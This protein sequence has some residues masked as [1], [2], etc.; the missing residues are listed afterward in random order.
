VIS[1]KEAPENV[2]VRRDAQRRERILEDRLAER[3]ALTEQRAQ[4][5][6]EVRLNKLRDQQLQICS[7]D[8]EQEVRLRQQAEAAPAEAPE[9]VKVRR[10]AQR[11][12]RI[13]EDR[14]AERIALT[15]QRARDRREARLN[16]LRDQQL[17]TGSADLEEE[18][19]LRQ[20]AE[21]RKARLQP[22]QSPM[23]ER[24][25]AQAWREDNTRAAG[26]RTQRRK[27][28]NQARLRKE[29]Q[30]VLDREAQ[31]AQ[32]REQLD[33]EAQRKRQ[34]TERLLEIEEIAATGRRERRRLAQAQGAEERRRQQRE[35]SASAD[36]QES[37]P[38]A[39]QPE[40]LPTRRLAPRE[41][42]YRRTRSKRQQEEEAFAAA[43]ET[44][45]LRL[46]RLHADFELETQ[47]AQTPMPQVASAE[48]DLAPEQPSGQLLRLRTH[49]SFVVDEDF[50]AVSLRGVTVIG[51]DTLAPAKDQS[52]VDALSLDDQNL[53]L[54]TNLWGINLIRLP[55]QSQTILSGNGTLSA[56]DILAGLDETVAAVSAVKAYVLLALQPLAGG[57]SPP[58]PDANAFQVWSALANHYQKEPCVLYEVFA[59]ATPLADNWLQTAATLA[60]T[61]RQQNPA[62]VIFL[63]SG[64]GGANVTGL[65]LLFPTG[66]P[67]FNLVYTISVSPQSPPD[68]DDGQLRALAESYPVFA[69]EWSDDNVNLGR[70]SSRIA[71][72]FDRYGIGWAAANWNG[73]PRLVTDSINHDFSATGWGLIAERA[74]KMPVK[75]LLK[76][77]GGPAV[78]SQVG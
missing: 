39:R 70:S 76:R 29:Q 2:K 66:E 12:E 54:M 64:K 36:L 3:I 77:L 14:Q 4:D 20:Q 73:E 38:P 47:A 15:E 16:R 17:Q 59:C 75:P 31:L 48:D 78:N 40:D 8:L 35:A 18:M 41:T 27:E 65:P 13:L 21:A 44:R 51:L 53:S 57:A 63:G 6:R 61:V 32:Q 9:N 26:V 43:S 30:S 10:D 55:F 50:D 37:H 1:P 25:T 28:M 49:G 42:L 52:F 45:G 23:R 56:D 19:R 71:D 68:Q 67:V 5:R 33:T 62:S 11:R 22:E 24:H 60:G 46:S 69:S 74:F 72:L 7:A 34:Q 58:A